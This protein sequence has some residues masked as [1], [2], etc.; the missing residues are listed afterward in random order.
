MK[1]SNKILVTAFSVYLLLTA[2]SLIGFKR[3]YNSIKEEATSLLRQLEQHRIHTLVNT[4]ERYISVRKTKGPRQF[5]GW[6][7][8]FDPK[9]IRIS[10]DTLYI[11]NRWVYVYLPYLETYLKNGQPVPIE[12]EHDDK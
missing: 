1:T 5:I 8:P 7:E 4:G 11:D 3:N 10:N 6:W 12:K 9:S 2:A